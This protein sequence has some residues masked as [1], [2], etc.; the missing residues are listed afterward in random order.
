MNNYFENDLWKLEHID[1]SANFGGSAI[2][3]YKVAFKENATIKD[4]VESIRN[5]PRQKFDREW[6]TVYVNGNKIMEIGDEMKINHSAYSEIKDAEIKECTCGR[7]WCCF[8]F[9]VKV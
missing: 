7:E 5:L 9:K 1:Y 8:E 2:S 3:R 6:G 4:F